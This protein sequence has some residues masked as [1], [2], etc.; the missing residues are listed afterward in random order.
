MLLETLTAAVS[1]HQFR[2]FG[3]AEPLR[4]IQWGVAVVPRP[5]RIG[6]VREAPTD[7]IDSDLRISQPRVFMKERT[8]VR[9]AR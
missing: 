7:G 3:S 4:H 9:V 2:D 5:V 6:A 1:P 8:A